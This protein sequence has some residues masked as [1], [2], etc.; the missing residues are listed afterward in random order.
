MDTTCDQYSYA[1]EP[2]KV[3]PGIIYTSSNGYF[4]F[5]YDEYCMTNHSTE[6]DKRIDVIVLPEASTQTA[7][8]VWVIE[9]KDFRVMTRQPRPGNAQDLHLTL[10]R[11]FADSHARL[12]SGKCDQNVCQRYAMA[13]NIHFCAH[14]EPPQQISVPP[15]VYRL[16]TS[17]ILNLTMHPSL[18][19]TPNG[20]TM[21]VFHMR[22]INEANHLPWQCS[23][24]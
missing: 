4:V 2:C 17:V 18:V 21:E 13:E 19:P 1:Q 14:I 16:L 10:A 5:A 3:S 8:D 6:H 24:P 23:N 11:K 9:A 22:K 12:I 20:S 7:E 15:P